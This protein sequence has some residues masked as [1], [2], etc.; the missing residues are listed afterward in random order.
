M[1]TTIEPIRSFNRP[2]DVMAARRDAYGNRIK[3]ESAQ[4]DWPPGH[5]EAKRAELLSK[6]LGEII[7]SFSAS[8]DEA[9]DALTTAI[10]ASPKTVSI[11]CRDCGAEYTR[12]PGNSSTR[13]CPG[14]SDSR[15]NE[16][17]ADTARRKKANRPPPLPRVRVNGKFVPRVA[18]GEPCPACGQQPPEGN[19]FC[20]ASCYRAAHKRTRHRQI[21][22][23]KPA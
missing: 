3:A 6:G 13:R 18:T 10:G 5:I 12:R 2:S 15:R 11:T 21:V 9:F 8:P 16:L 23:A 4:P 19:R 17:A 20:D 22:E 7:A 1:T 14:C